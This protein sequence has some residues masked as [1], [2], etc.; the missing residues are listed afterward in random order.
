MQEKLIVLERRRKFVAIRALICGCLTN[1]ALGTS[2][3][4]ANLIDFMRI[5]FDSVTKATIPFPLSMIV[6]GCKF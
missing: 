3:L 6:V 1:M 4:Y 5:R 2:F